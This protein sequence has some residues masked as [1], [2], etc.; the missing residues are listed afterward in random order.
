MLAEG[1]D[2]RSYQ[3]NLVK[4][5]LSA[6]QSAVTNHFSQSQLKSRIV[7]LNRPESAKTTWLRYPVL[8][9]AALT[10]ATVFAQPSAQTLK[11]FVPAPVAETVALMVAADEPGVE[12]AILVQTPALKDTVRKTPAQDSKPQVNAPLV[13]AV[14]SVRAEPNLDSARTSSSRYMLYKG[15]YL[16]WVVTPKTTFDDFAVMKQ[17]FAKHGHQMQLM[18]VKYDPLYAYIDQINFKVVRPTGGMTQVDE[19]DDDTKPIPAVAG[20]VG[21]SANTGESGTGSLRY[22]Q[23][24]FPDALRKIAVDDSLA[25]VKHIQK[26]SMAYLMH[27][28]DKKFGYLGGASTTFTKGNFGKEIHENSGLTIQP[29]G[30]LSVVEKLGAV[31]VFI[32]NEPASRDAVRKLKVEQLYSVVSMIAHNPATREQFTTALLIYVN[33]DN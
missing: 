16:Y 24:E 33:E 22:Y 31:Q 8:C 15:G 30:T 28:G 4:V 3:Y 7:M 5:S 26:N 25:I 10:V 20:Y 9:L 23:R 2:A 19:I 12:S 21:I 29:D 6:G 13:A 11:K 17:E 14:D 32:N 1:V 18:E 27:A